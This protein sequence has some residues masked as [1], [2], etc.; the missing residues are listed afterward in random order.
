[1]LSTQL[2][3]WGIFSPTLGSLDDLKDGDKI[4][5]PND[6]PNAGRALLLLES[7]GLIEI[8]DNA[9]IVPTEEDLTA[10]KKNLEFQ[11]I[12]AT[13]IPQQYD[14]PSLAAVVV[15]ANYFDPSQKV[16]LD[17]AL[18]ADDA[19]GETTLPYVNAIVTRADNADNPEWE[20]LREAF[21]DQR[22]KDAFDKEFD[23]SAVLVDVPRKDLE[24]NLAK[25]EEEARS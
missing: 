7:A 21:A 2:V 23:G 12:E 1:M 4:A 13:T 24:G 16:T 3:R 15:G 19:E 6:A 17:D 14:D 9:G 25:L 18:F 11:P 22:V 5:I 10:N 20:L 8:D